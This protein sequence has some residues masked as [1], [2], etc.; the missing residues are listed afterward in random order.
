MDRS[1]SLPEIASFWMG[2]R[3]SFIEILCLKSFV[4]LGHKFTLYTYEDIINVP[5]GVELVDGEKIVPRA[6]FEEFKSLDAAAVFSDKFRIYM[7]S[8][9]NKIWVDC[10]AY[11][12]KPF[13]DTPY[14]IAA[15]TPERLANGVLRLPQDSPALKGYRQF[16]SSSHPI[17]PHDWWMS[18][19]LIRQINEHR[20]HIIE[21]PNLTW[22]PFALTYF[23]TC[24]GEIAYEMPGER[25]YPLPGISINRVFQNYDKIKGF[26]PHDCLSVHLFGSLL[27]RRVKRRFPDDELPK[28]CFL[29]QLCEKHDVDV[30][31]WPVTP[32]I[33]A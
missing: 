12:W 31:E 33:H 22:G 18:A 6:D 17:L 23:L 3:L 32:L 4:D 2:D 29:N 25:F 26:F 7:L 19:P 1:L 16:V 15:D 5:K 11:A 8:K 28:D 24:S 13:P 20:P 21:M 30:R 9:T 10:D 14:I 27:R